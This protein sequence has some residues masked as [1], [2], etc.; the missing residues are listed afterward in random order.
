MILFNSN[1]TNVVNDEKSIDH[2]S[3]NIYRQPP[4]VESMEFS[5]HVNVLRSVFRR[6]IEICGQR[7][8]SNSSHP[9]GCFRFVFFFNFVQ[10][11]MCRSKM[12]PVSANLRIAL[13]MNRTILL[14]DGHMM[15]MN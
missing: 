7:A 10:Y 11:F 14:Y 12:M 5:Q 1:Y 3:V 2:Q 13:T 4:R 6:F 8:V 15:M 9:M